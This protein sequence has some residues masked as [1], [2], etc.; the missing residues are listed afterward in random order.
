MTDTRRYTHVHT[1]HIRLVLKTK[2]GEK[3]K[4]PQQVKGPDLEVHQQQIKNAAKNHLVK[5]GKLLYKISF[6]KAINE[7]SIDGKFE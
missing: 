7:R 2:P 3:V 5:E 4:W 6:T 1:N